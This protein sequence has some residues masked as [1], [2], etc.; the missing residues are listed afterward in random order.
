MGTACGFGAGGGSAA[1]GPSQQLSAA[2]PVRVSVSE[3]AGSLLPQYLELVV[4][5]CTWLERA[6]AAVDRGPAHAQLQ[7][8]LQSI[9]LLLTQQLSAPKG[10]AVT[11][12]VL[13][14][15]FCA[16]SGSFINSYPPAMPHFGRVLPFSVSERQRI[17]ARCAG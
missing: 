1:A 3:A 9:Q 5:L 7:G 16:A 13:L 11:P 12:R 4:R 15:H 17:D 14:Y 6:A 10:T 8:Q 2:G